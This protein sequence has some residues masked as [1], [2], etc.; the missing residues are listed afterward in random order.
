MEKRHWLL[1]DDVLLVDKFP[2]SGEQ[3]E[4]KLDRCPFSG[5]VKGVPLKLLTKNNVESI[6]ISEDKAPF[7]L[8]F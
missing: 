8:L 4:E 6:V 5:K 2:N 1:N 7:G 3:K